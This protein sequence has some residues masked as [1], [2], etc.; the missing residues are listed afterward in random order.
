MAAP[1]GNK[2]AENAKLAKRALEH[3][4]AVRSGTEQPKDGIERFNAL[5]MIWDKQIEKAMSGDNQSASMIFD[6]LDGKPAQSVE[7]T[8]EV[9]VT[10]EQW[11]DNL[12]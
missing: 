10:H 9:T 4:I 5:V 12:Q 8:A 11:L 3:A 6:R 7:M 2:F 1:K